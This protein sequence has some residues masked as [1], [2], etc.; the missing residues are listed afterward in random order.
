MAS[1]TMTSDDR[2][3]VHIDNAAMADRAGGRNNFAVEPVRYA[4]GS[5]NNKRSSCSSRLIDAR[6]AQ[7]VSIS[8]ATRVET[9]RPGIERLSALPY[10]LSARLAETAISSTVMVIPVPAV[11]SVVFVIAMPRIEPTLVLTLT[12]TALFKRSIASTIISVG[13]L[14]SSDLSFSFGTIWRS[15]CGRG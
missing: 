5:L 14:L 1:A 2:I 12:M 8:K 3:K 7:E 11:I 9:I 4:N 6:A 15:Q 10:G 13:Q